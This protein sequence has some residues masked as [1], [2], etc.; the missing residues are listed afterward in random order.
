MDNF[1]PPPTQ[2][3]VQPAVSTTHEAFFDHTHRRRDPP[4]CFLAST[5]EDQCFQDCAI[6]RTHSVVGRCLLTKLPCISR[7]HDSLDGRL[8]YQHPDLHDCVA[9]RQTIAISSKPSRYDSNPPASILYK[10]S[11]AIAQQDL[12]SYEKIRSPWTLRVMSTAHYLCYPHCKTQLA[13]S[14]RTISHVW[15]TKSHS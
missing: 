15:Q 6:S 4:R 9:L 13:P 3:P 12:W 14:G 1:S 5:F 7:G 10:W 11:S 2:P 8:R